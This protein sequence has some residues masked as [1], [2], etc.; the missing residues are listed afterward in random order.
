M[1]L[2]CA[3]SFPFSQAE[4]QLAKTLGIANKILQ[5]KLTDNELRYVYQH[6][7]LF[8]FPSTYEGFGIPMLEAFDAGV[9]V[10]ANQATSLPEVGGDAA[11]Y[12]N[13]TNEHQ[14]AEAVLYLMNNSVTRSEMV[15]KGFSRVQQFN[16]QSHIKQTIKVYN[17]AAS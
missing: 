2:Y 13:A 16:W 8:I 4:K 3:G 15:K 12:V 5:A 11:L 10:I 7:Q 17:E 9:P 14:L 6:A 1:F